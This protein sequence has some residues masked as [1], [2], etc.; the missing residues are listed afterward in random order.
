ML[1]CSFLPGA[2]AEKTAVVRETPLMAQG[3][4]VLFRKEPRT[5]PSYPNIVCKLKWARSELGN[6]SSRNGSVVMLLAVKNSNI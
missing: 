4:M 1:G 6:L 3:V 2:E 5:C